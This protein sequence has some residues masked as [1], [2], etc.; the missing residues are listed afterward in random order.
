MRSLEF[1]RSS[2]EQKFCQSDDSTPV[3]SGSCQRTNGG[4]FRK[5]RDLC[6][7]FNAYDLLRFVRRACHAICHAAACQRRASNVCCSCPVSSPQS[8]ESMVN[9]MMS[10]PKGMRIVPENAAAN[11]Y[12]HVTKIRR[13]SSEGCSH[14]GFGPLELIDDY[15]AIY[16]LAL[17]IIKRKSTARHVFLRGRKVPLQF[18][19]S[20]DIIGTSRLLQMENS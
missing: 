17:R 6:T 1:Q 14:Y 11:G 16:L 9:G 19:F 7:R 8:L 13:G 5:A 18:K 3:S 20:V 2:C 12:H 4:R 15:D 10:F